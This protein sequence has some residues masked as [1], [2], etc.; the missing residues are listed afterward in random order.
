MPTPH[1]YSEWTKVLDIFKAKEDDTGILSV[2]K[3]G[4]LEWQSGVAERFSKRLV[5]AVNTRMNAASDKFQRDM[6][7]ARGEEGAIVQ[8]LL[9][10]RKELAFL[11]QAMDIPALPEEYRKQYIQ[12]VSD[13]AKNVQI[14]LEDSARKDRSGKMS[15]IVRNHRVDVF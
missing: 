1:T 4:T 10:L 6:N 2:M 3:E 12:L 11:V 8:A 15:S 13:Q 14:S 7:Y 5:E 9:A